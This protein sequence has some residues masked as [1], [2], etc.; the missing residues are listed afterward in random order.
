[1]ASLLNGTMIAAPMGVFIPRRDTDSGLTALAGDRA[2]PGIHRLARFG[3]QEDGP[4]L[5]IDVTSHDGGLELSVSAHETATLGSRLFGSL[6]DAVDFF[7]QGSLGFSP[8][9]P[10]SASWSAS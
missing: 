3:V 1:M 8:S 4:A 10:T 2:F 5:R 6:E 9:G 7:R